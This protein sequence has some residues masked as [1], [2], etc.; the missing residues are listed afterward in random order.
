MGLLFHTMANLRESIHWRPQ[1]ITPAITSISYAMGLTLMGT[2][3]R[4]YPVV[5][6]LDRDSTLG[7][8]LWV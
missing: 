5:L 4:I 3:S 2:V 6:S 7:A 8:D 1:Y